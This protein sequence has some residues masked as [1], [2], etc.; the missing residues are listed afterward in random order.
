MFTD[1]SFLLEE[2]S[3]LL[4]NIE[5][6]TKQARSYIEDGIGDTEEAIRI[7][8][9][10]RKKRCIIL[11]AVMLIMLAAMHFFFGFNPFG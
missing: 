1:F 7:N 6:Q 3:E 2:Q 10:I 8:K 5:F 11:I 9:K 4:D